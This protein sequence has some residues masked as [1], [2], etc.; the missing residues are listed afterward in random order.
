MKV[1]GR[2]SYSTCSL[3]PIENESVVAS[4]LKE[5]GE[6][7]KIEEVELKG[8]KF[9]QGLTDWKVLVEK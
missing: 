6:Y 1:G 3:N 8:F 4:V 7:I 5:Y 2:I 9:R